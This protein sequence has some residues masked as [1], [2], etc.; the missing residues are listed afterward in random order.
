[1][2]Q[3]PYWEGNSHSASQDIRRP[4]WNPKIHNRVHKGPPLVPTLSQMHPVNAFPPYFPNIHSNI[5]F[6]STPRSSK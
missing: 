2:E 6:P 5:I 1:M 4:L 3:S